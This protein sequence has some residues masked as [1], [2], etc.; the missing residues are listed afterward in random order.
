MQ[1][2]LKSKYILMKLSKK[3]KCPN[4]YIFNLKTKRCNKCPKGYIVRNSYTRKSKSTE[5]KKYVHESCIKS[6][7]LPGKTSL[8][9]GVDNP[10]IGPLKKGELGRY[11]YHGVLDLSEAQRHDALRNAVKDM[12]ADK[13]VKKLGAIRTYLKNTSPKASAIFYKDQRWVRKTY[14]K[15]F[16]GSLKKSKLYKSNN[17]F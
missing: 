17:N 14:A 7:G 5:A 11:G 3:K 15:L 1:N 4:Y 13:L 2:S 9:Y 10:G 8:R 6:Q 16:K 12:G